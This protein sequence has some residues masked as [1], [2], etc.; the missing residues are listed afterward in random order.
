MSLRLPPVYPITDKELAGRETH[1]EIVRELI[2]GGA[3][4]IQVRD[5][6]TPVR[7]LLLDLERTVELAARHDAAIVV[8]DRVDLAL[9]AGAAGVHVGQ[10]DLPAAAVRTVLG[11]RALV[12]LSSHTARQFRR[13][14]A[15]PV[16]YVAF[17]P[18]FGTATK[19]DAAAV[20]GLGMLR[21][22]ARSSTRPV[23]AIG[24]IGLDR[25]REVLDAGA[26]SVAVI[27]AVMG[28]DPA[29]RMARLLEAATEP[30]STGKTSGRL[31]ARDRA[32]A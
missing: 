20:V 14:L 18:I 15:E 22:I 25:V 3:R 32:P 31:Q 26:A 10:D 27:G 9:L 6:H 23:V 24:G 17:G 28:P 21:R 1:R 7:E 12:G 4:L 19:P 16:D 2:R 13:A 29:R 30:Q 11:R 5:K 8:N